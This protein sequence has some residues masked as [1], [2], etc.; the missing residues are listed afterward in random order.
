VRQLLAI[1]IL[2]LS[3]CNVQQSDPRN[4]DVRQAFY[5]DDDAD[6]IGDEDGAVYIGC[7][8]PVGYVNVPP[9]VD[10]NTDTDLDTDTDLGTDTDLDSDTDSGMNAR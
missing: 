6:G 5:A 7:E 8:A 4:C 2:T 1:A 10:N 9:P 3:A